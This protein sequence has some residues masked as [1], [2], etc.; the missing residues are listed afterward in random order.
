MFTLISAF[1]FPWAY[2]RSDRVCRPVRPTKVADPA[3]IANFFLCLCVCSG[4]YV[5]V[6]WRSRRRESPYSVQA[7]VCIRAEM[8]ILNVLVTYLP[9]F[10][11]YLRPTLF[12]HEL[13][14][15]MAC[16]FEFSGGL[17]N[18][19]TYALQ[20]RYAA[21]LTGGPSAI[22]QQRD[23]NRGGQSYSVEFA[24]DVDPPIEFVDSLG[25]EWD[26]RPKRG[27]CSQSRHRCTQN[28]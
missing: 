4:C 26:V 2:D 23:T 8:Y 24:E 15:T 16:V 27:T 14:F 5:V 13:L 10:V 20:S 22:R 18:T 25:N 17:L 9:I 1:F 12:T 19:L 28:F 6:V 11:L 7:R 3:T 21:R